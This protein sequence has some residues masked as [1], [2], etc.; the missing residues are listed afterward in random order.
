M[1]VPSPGA[2]CST[3]RLPCELELLSQAR[4]SSTV[5]VQGASSPTACFL[6]AR[7][8]QELRPLQEH[9]PIVPRYTH[10]FLPDLPRLEECMPRSSSVVVLVKDLG[11][12]CKSCFHFALDDLGTL[13]QDP[14]AEPRDT[15]PPPIGSSS[16]GASLRP[17]PMGLA[18]GQF[19][20]P[21]QK[22]PMAAPPAPARASSAATSMGLG[23]GSSSGSTMGPPLQVT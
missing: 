22:P 16:G 5:W 2:C 19:D 1:A 11:Q 23:A 9:V 15:P 3:T 8:P 17:D 10:S 21:K 12:S 18:S 6:L 20:A 13:V 7:L 14:V 4:L